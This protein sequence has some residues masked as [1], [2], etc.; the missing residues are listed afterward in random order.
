MSKRYYLDKFVQDSVGRWRPSIAL[1]QAW[2]DET[3]GNP[4]A[5]YSVVASPPDPQTGEP[6]DKDCLLAVNAKGHSALGALENVE[7]MPDFPLDSKVGSMHVA[8][9]QAMRTFLIARGVPGSVTDNADGF[10]DIVEYIA[11]VKL[12]NEGFSADTFEA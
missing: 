10:R 1:S 11:R 9:K 12:G 2:A 5:A 8:T 7:L 3:A 4:D 6:I